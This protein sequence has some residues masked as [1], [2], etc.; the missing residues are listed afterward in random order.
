MI[1]RNNTLSGNLRTGLFF[2]TKRTLIPTQEL[3]ITDSES[4]Q[5]FPMC[6]DCALPL[7][8][9]PLAPSDNFQNDRYYS[10]IYNILSTESIVAKIID[11]DGVEYVVS[12]NSYGQL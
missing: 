3:R 10:F 2:A 6:Y 7:F 1:F 11:S 9:N 5:S 12:D 4:C 8:A